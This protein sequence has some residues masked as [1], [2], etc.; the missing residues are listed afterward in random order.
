VVALA[1]LILFFAFPGKAYYTTPGFIMPK[2]Y[3]NSILAVLNARFRIVGGR[4]TYISSSDTANILSTP[5]YLRPRETPASGSR[6]SSTVGNSKS[7]PLVA[8]DTKVFVQYD[9]DR[10]E[11]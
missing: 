10:E 4:A 11:A 1:N 9:G 6:N 3:A 8:V 7:I 5:T 2:L